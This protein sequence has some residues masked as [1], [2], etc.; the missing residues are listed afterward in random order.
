MLC[1]PQ[2]QVEKHLLRTRI[3]LLFLQGSV[4]VAPAPGTCHHPT[5][6]CQ[7]EKRPRMQVP[8]ARLAWGFIS[9]GRTRYRKTVSKRSYDAE[10]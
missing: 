3:L 2:T 8:P 9:V 1:L 10:V 5:Q 4:C 7:M 6:L